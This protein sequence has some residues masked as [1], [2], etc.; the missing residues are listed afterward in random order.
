MRTLVNCEVMI[1]AHEV[2][3]VNVTKKFGEVL[4]VNN[5]SLNIK[6]GEFVSILDPQVVE[7]L[8]HYG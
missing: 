3:L 6:E 5:L 8:P 1:L 2:S 7:K 4:A